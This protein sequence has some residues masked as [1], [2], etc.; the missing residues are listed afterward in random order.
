MIRHIAAGFLISIFYFFKC[1]SFSIYSNY[2][3][4]HIFFISIKNHKREYRISPK[5]YIYLWIWKLHRV[6]RSSEGSGTRNMGF[7]I[8][9]CHRK[10]ILMEGEHGFSSFFCHICLFFKV[11]RAKASAKLL[12]SCLKWPL[13][14]NPFFGFQFRIPENPVSGTQSVTNRQQQGQVSS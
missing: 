13:C 8:W 10:M 9:K 14:L 4:V 1:V 6:Q 5:H 3:K 11:E 12:H 7:G 2:T